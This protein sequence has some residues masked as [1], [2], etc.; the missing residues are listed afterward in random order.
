MECVHWTRSCHRSLEGNSWFTTIDLVDG[1]FSLPLYP[2]DRGFTAF[3]T[4][5]GTFKWNVLPQGTAAS[6][7]IFQ[8]V[9]DRWF[10][11]Y[12]WKNVIVW[13]DDIL[14]FSKTFKQ[15]LIALRSVFQVLRKYGLV[16]SRRKIKT[17]MRS[18][19][20]LGFIFGVHGIRTDPDKLSAVHQIPAPKSRKQVRQF[21]GFANFYRRFM[22]PNYASVVAPLTALTSEK[23]PFRWDARCR[24]AFDKV[25]L[26]LTSTPVLVHPDFSLPFHI[27]CDASGLGVGA[28]L[29]Q[30]VDGAYRPIAFCSKKLLPHQAHWAP[31][32]LEAYA[33]FHAVVEKWRY[34]LSLNK[35]IVHS[36]HRNLIWLFKHSHKGMIGRWYAS[37]SAFDLDITYVS[38]ESQIVADPLSRLFDEVTEGSY[39]Q[40]TNPAVKALIESTP[41]MLLS[42]MTHVRFM[43]MPQVTLHG[44]RSALYVGSP[45]LYAAPALTKLPPH[46]KSIVE[47]LANKDIT[48]SIPRAVW[49]SH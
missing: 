24:Y 15:H 13:I 41:A 3:H 39:D 32:Q 5:I 48:K 43:Q 45:P 20:Y 37:L 31:A 21:L 34:Y 25:K 40:R 16:V 14:I 8:R 1:F 49:A 18:V 11:T 35:C 30:Y 17:C 23:M 33:I 28:V 27:H 9:M 42:T 38:G 6:P 36:D 10:A 44:R 47:S 19:R 26:L 7:A 2:A 12:L 4:P 29:S 46:I 22:P